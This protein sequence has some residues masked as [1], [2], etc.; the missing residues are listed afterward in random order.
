M[1][2]QETAQPGAALGSYVYGIVRA[3]ER[4]PE[5]LVPV[6]GEGDEARLGL[7][8]HERVAAVVSDVPVDRPLGSRQDLMA[9]EQVL[10]AIAQHTTV[11]PMRFGGVVT[12]DDAVT[13]ELLGP[14]EDYFAWAL[15]QVE[16]TAQ[17]TLRGSYDE[18][19]L[20][21]RIVSADPEIRRLSE[22]IREVDEDAGYYDRI[23]L[24]EAISQ[25]M[26]AVRD[27]DTA[28]VLRRLEP[29]VIATSPHQA[30][31]DYGAVHVAVLVRS[32]HRT[33]FERIVDD[34][35]EEWDGRVELRLVGPLAPFDFVPEMPEADPG[36]PDP[37][38]P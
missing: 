26:D 16:G 18:G 22:R 15:E 19:A 32:D 9:H 28:A 12:D 10:N 23:A 35:G 2:Q 4:L 21:E 7:V 24:G 3:G 38:E 36:A 20:M 1:T 25:A 14:H 13:D 11:L 33:D 30:S 6:R 29:S 31:G 5:D 17:F 34:L 27:E 8:S 37:A